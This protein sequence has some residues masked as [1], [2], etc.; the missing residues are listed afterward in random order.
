M[1]LTGSSLSVIVPSEHTCCAIG[2][3]RTLA[4]AASSILK[5]RSDGVSAV[6]VTGGEGGGRLGA[7]RTSSR[8]KWA[9]LRPGL[10]EDLHTLPVCHA[11][12]YR[13]K[14]RRAVSWCGVSP[15]A[16]LEDSMVQLGGALVMFPASAPHQ[17]TPLGCRGAAACSAHTHIGA[18]ACGSLRA[19]PVHHFGSYH[20]CMP[21]SDMVHPASCASQRL[22]AQGSHLR[23]PVACLKTAFLPER[24]GLAAFTVHAT[25]GGGRVW[26]ACLHA[27][28]TL[29]TLP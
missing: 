5:G 1:R 19:C 4:W 15:H 9:S 2:I 18:D 25:V 28:A 21:C 16:N 24:G 11:S 17:P 29:R 22:R 27:A 12:L 7:C 13:F 14:S 8:R 10:S 3:T 6:G 20:L 26:M 23:H